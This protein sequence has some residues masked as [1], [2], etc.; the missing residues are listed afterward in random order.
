[1]QPPRPDVV[2]AICKQVCGPISE[3]PKS[4]RENLKFLS[5]PFMIKP[6]LNGYLC[7][8]LFHCR[9]VNVFEYRGSPPSPLGIL[10]Y[11]LHTKLS[12]SEAF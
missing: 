3:I 2:T 1:M 9:N 7:F 5:I 11:T 6:D 12:K 10:Q 8:Y 4:K